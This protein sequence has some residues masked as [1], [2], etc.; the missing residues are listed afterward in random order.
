MPTYS[1]L[2]W[3]KYVKCELPYLVVYTDRADVYIYNMNMN[4]CKNIDLMYLEKPKLLATFGVMTSEYG[5]TGIGRK[6]LLFFHERG[7]GHCGADADAVYHVGCII[8]Q[9][10]NG[11][12]CVVFSVVVVVR[13]IIL[14]PTAAISQHLNSSWYFVLKRKRHSVSTY[15]RNWTT[16]QRLK[17]PV[18]SLHRYSR[19]R[20]V[21]SL[22]NNIILITSVAFVA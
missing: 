15:S 7:C 1:Q 13:D 17:L 9:F 8:L 2:G 21:S 22:E 11:F 14:G 3:N 18:K 10:L 12:W 5:L 19:T 4:V 20:S 16:T 6:Y